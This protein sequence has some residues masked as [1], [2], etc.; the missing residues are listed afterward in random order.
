MA[1]PTKEDLEEVREEMQAQPQELSDIQFSAQIAAEYTE[2]REPSDTAPQQEDI[3]EQAVRAQDEMTRRDREILDALDRV[4]QKSNNAPTPVRKRRS[5]GI[6][7]L[8]VGTIKRGAGLVSLAL[9]LMFLGIVSMCVMVSGT[10]DRLL[11]AK[12]APITAVFVGAEL[13][14]SWLVSGRKLRINI[15]CIC[16]TAFITIGS[17]ILSASLSSTEKQAIEEYNSRMVSAEIYDASYSALRHSADIS[18][19]TVTAELDPDSKARSIDT[20]SAGDYVKIT[21][22]LDGRYSTPGEFAADCG[23]M[24]RVYKDLGIPVDTFSFSAETRL[25][26]FFLTVEGKF[27]QDFSDEELTELV[28]YIFYEDYDYIQDLEDMTEETTEHIIE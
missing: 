5:T 8:A 28:N 20:L 3:I 1:V 14:L 15:P 21:A 4:L 10:P 7:R 27:Q 6:G 17:C 22:V 23:H 2:S 25:A 11:I 13:L 19:L 26:G 24:I 9:S 16:V 18:K 12:L